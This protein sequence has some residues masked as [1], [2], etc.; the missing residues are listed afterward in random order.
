MQKWLKTAKNALETLFLGRLR[1]K[2][3]GKWV[4]VLAS[5]F[6]EGFS[7]LLRGGV[8]QPQLLFH[9]PQ[10]V[11][12]LQGGNVVEVGAFQPVSQGLQ[13]RIVKLEH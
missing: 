7:E 2:K 4:K 9:T 8:L 1:S 13:E 5:V 10:Q 3:G 11:E 6:E 12:G